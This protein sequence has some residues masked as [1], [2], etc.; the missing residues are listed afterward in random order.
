MS[1]P[2]LMTRLRGLVETRVKLFNVYKGV[3]ISYEATIKHVAERAIKL[4][5]ARA[6]AV[7]LAFERQTRMEVPGFSTIVEGFVSEI[8]IPTETV[9][10]R[11][12][13][14]A[15]TALLRRMETRVEPKD[16]VQVE[17]E[18]SRMKLNTQL[19]DISGSGMGLMVGS[20]Y[21]TP[22]V[23]PAGSEITARLFGLP[24]SRNPVVVQG[25]VMY[26]R[27][28]LDQGRLGI[29][30]VAS[31]L[32]TPAIRDYIGQRQSE[33]MRELNLVYQAEVQKRLKK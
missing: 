30:G 15:L 1:T 31:L 21:A 9:W 3:L 13:H 33:I 2:D 12:L 8:D 5:V 4:Q 19:V 32:N 18:T 28:E 29:G 6:Q 10:L 17:V 24:T 14:P 16:P 7:A 22:T 11:D 20:L 27:N 23:F 25:R 26:V